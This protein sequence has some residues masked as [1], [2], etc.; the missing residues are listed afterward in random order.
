VNRS[1][2]T[3]LTVMSAVSIV[4]LTAGPALAANNP[5]GPREGADPGPGLSAAATIGLFLVVPLAIIAAISAL[6]LLPGL[7][8]GTRY[9]PTKGWDAAPVWFA[10]PLDPVAA[11]ADAQPGDV[12]RGGA[13]GSW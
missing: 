13:S 6:V 11:V 3:G 5:L 12:V 9:R 8:R 1:R 4:L 7:V 2:R 10:G